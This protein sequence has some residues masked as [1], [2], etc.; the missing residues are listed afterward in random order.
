MT[1][2]Q[3]TS[4][5][6]T[7]HSY[8]LCSAQKCRDGLAA[9]SC[10]PYSVG[11]GVGLWPSPCCSVIVL[12]RA[13]RA[14]CGTTTFALG[15]SQF[16]CLACSRCAY[17]FSCTCCSACV[18]LQA[19]FVGVLIYLCICAHAC[20]CVCPYCNA[21]DTMKTFSRCWKLTCD[22]IVRVSVR[23]QKL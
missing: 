23:F 1:H 6:W 4:S 7:E 17:A 21:C 3:Q 12:Q 10:A 2:A 15:C 22:G 9:Y 14:A 18:M 16:S 19:S 5:L 13:S 8:D 11:N 20:L